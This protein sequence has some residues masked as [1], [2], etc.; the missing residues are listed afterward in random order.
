MDARLTTHHDG[1]LGDAIE[2]FHALLL[3]ETRCHGS[4]VRILFQE[5]FGSSQMVAQVAVAAVM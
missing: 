1:L 3:I 2:L 5:P 4:G